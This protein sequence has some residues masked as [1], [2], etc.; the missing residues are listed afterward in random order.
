MKEQAA[1]WGGLGVFYVLTQK[2]SP[3]PCQM[4]RAHLAAGLGFLGQKGCH[5]PSPAATNSAGKPCLLCWGSWHCSQPLE[6]FLY[7][8][9]GVLIIESKMHPCHP[10]IKPLQWL[11]LSSG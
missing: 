11:P 10:L 7:L 3:R 6:S 2:G 4:G 5:Q 1:R 9:A 8:A